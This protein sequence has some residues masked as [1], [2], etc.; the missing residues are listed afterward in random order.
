MDINGLEKGELL[1][2]LEN[3]PADIAYLK[4]PSE[5]IQLFIVKINSKLI[6]FI[7]KPCPKV[8][9]YVIEQDVN[10]IK[11]CNTQHENDVTYI[12]KNSVALISH[13]HTWTEKTF[14]NYV[15]TNLV[16]YPRV[17][18]NALKNINWTAK[19]KKTCIQETSG[20]DYMLDTIIPHFDTIKQEELDIV[21]NCPEAIISIPNP[22]DKTIISVAKSSPHLHG[23]LN[24]Y[25]GNNLPTTAKKIIIKNRI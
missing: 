13:I 7:D 10:N 24:A 4:N 25:C 18:A 21:T 5:D 23:V 3:N 1:K 20:I 22:Q 19:G 2:H 8:T 11:L 6:V 16:T 14:T 9:K 17:C 15:T 12:I